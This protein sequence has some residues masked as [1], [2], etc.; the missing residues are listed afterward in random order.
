M[1][2]KKLSIGRQFEDDDEKYLPIRDFP[3]FISAVPLL[4]HLDISGFLEKEGGQVL[5]ALKV[6]DLRHL[7]GLMYLD[8]SDN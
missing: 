4:E 6:V 3:S 2:L 7:F 8:L 1:P 5:V